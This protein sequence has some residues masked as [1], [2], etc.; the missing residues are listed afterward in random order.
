MKRRADLLLAVAL[1]F[2]YL[3]LLLGTSGS[4]GFTR[5][6]GFYFA[7]ARTYESWFELLWSEPTRALS[8]AVSDRYWAVN[9]EHP[10]L[11]KSLFALSHHLAAGLFAEESSSFRLPG[12]LLSS[13][14]VSVTF[15]WGRRVFGRSG[16]LV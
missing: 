11:I 5:D 6:E 12:M 16:A 14:A 15:V 3:A 13:L 9:H 4:L 1:F 7:S 8:P 2:G 10:A